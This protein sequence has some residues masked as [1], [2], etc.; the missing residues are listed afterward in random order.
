MLWQGKDCPITARFGHHVGRREALVYVFQI[1]PN[2]RILPSFGGSTARQSL[3]RRVAPR[4]PRVLGHPLPCS[5]SLQTGS[6]VLH[7]SG[8]RSPTGANYNS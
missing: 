6:H 7:F 1:P 4:T 8:T 5:S 3:H 2:T